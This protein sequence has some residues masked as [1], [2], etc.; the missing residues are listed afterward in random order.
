MHSGA[1]RKI[2]HNLKTVPKIS[3]AIPHILS[4][5]WFE[6][7]YRDVFLILEHGLDLAGGGGGVRLLP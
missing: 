2:R 7:C 6:D 1:L 3:E 4:R 5:L